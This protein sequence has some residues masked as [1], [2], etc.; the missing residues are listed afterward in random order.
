MDGQPYGRKLRRLK[1]TRTLLINHK[2]I[3]SISRRSF[4]LEV[5]P[6]SSFTE[7]LHREKKVDSSL[8][9]GKSVTSHK[10]KEA[11]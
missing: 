2:L 9:L 10:R 1:P 6:D 8:L 7:F 3:S 4:D 11:F 5:S